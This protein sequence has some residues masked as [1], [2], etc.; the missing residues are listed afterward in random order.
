MAVGFLSLLPA[1]LFISGLAFAKD[2]FGSELALALSN[3]S[4]KSE[5][6]G[7]FSLNRQGLLL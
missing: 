1:N 3:F 7:S 4:S 2:K 6:T 5:T